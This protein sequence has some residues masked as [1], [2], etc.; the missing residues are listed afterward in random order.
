MP[1]YLSENADAVQMRSD[2]LLTG[3]LVCRV[4][5]AAKY[6]NKVEFLSARAHMTRCQ[7]GGSDTLCRWFSH[8]EGCCLLWSVAVLLYAHIYINRFSTG[9]GWS[10]RNSTFSF[11][12]CLHTNML[13]VIILKCFICK[14]GK[15]EE[16]NLWRFIR[17]QCK[18]NRMQIYGGIFTHRKVSNLSPVTSHM[19]IWRGCQ[20][21]WASLMLCT[22]RNPEHT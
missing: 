21:T 2:K 15:Y 19:H 1:R 9:Q 3:L 16:R 17:S 6:L 10:T 18:F 20:W 5:A 8:C 14:K 4:S 12:R 7:W 11:T 22:L 13:S